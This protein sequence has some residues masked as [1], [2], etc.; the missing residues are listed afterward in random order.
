MSIL[1]PFSGS[2][3]LAPR[4]LIV[5][6]QF[7]ALFE[8]LHLPRHQRLSG[9][10]YGLSGLGITD[11]GCASSPVLLLIV[12]IRH[13][14][15]LICAR[16]PELAQRRHLSSPTTAAGSRSSGA[17][18]QASRTASPILICNCFLSLPAQPVLKIRLSLVGISVSVL[19]WSRS[20]RLDTPMLAG[21]HS[22]IVWFVVFLGG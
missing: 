9:L 17:A 20:C 14:G 12:A 13:P 8:L 21:F 1:T 11:L 5:V 10:D 7:P 22:P 15:V 16:R 3:I 6:V 18:I 2:R 4:P 19:S